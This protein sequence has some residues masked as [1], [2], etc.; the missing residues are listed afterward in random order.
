[1]A[2]TYATDSAERKTVPFFLAAAGIG[3]AYLTFH[4]LQKY[5]I[6]LP[7]WA[8]LPIDTMGLYGL[9]YLLFDRFVWKWRLIR[10]LGLSRV[11]DLSGAWHGQV[12]PAPT[13]GV[14]AGLGAPIDITLSISQTWTEILIKA[15]TNQSRS[16]S[17]SGAIVVAD[18][19]SLSYEYV[20]E[21]SASAP[22]TMHAHRGVVRLMLNPTR[23]VLEGEYYSGRDRQTIGSI[24]VARS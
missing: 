5:H 7:W 23:T 22:V 12:Q 18:D 13:Q 19:A 15:E 20:N 16:R 2:H 1:M 8:F 9:F 6:E 21:P 11:P 4:I 17:L 24:R 10:W 14:S 3:G